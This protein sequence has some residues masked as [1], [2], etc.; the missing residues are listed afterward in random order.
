MKNPFVEEAYTKA[1]EVLRECE[2]DLGLKA[3]ALDEGY[4]QVWGR[5]SMISSLGILLTDDHTLQEASRKSLETLRA[6][7]TE[8]GLIPNNV[9]V[10]VKEA[11]YHAYMDGNFWYVIAVHAFFKKTNDQDFLKEYY[12]SVKKTLT[13]L[14]YQD[15][16]KSGLLSSQEATDWQDQFSVRG[17]IL[18][19]N[20]LYYQALRKGAELATIMGEKEN[21]R[22]YQ[23]R[24]EKV[25]RAINYLFWVRDTHKDMLP[26][27]ENGEKEFKNSSAIEF[28]KLL[29]AENSLY[30][31]RRPY[32]LAFRS[33]HQ[34]GEWF[35]TL[36]NMLAILFEVADSKKA[37]MILD[38]AAQAGIAMPYPAKAIDPPIFPGDTEWREYFKKANLNLPYQYHNGG[39]WPFVGGFY[40]AALVKA[41]RQEEAEKQLESLAKVNHLGKRYEW[42]F[43][44]WF[45]G[46]HGTPMG[47]EKQAWSAAMYVFAYHCVKSGKVL[48]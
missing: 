28:E 43:N 15:V 6:F 14:L 38:F 21:A 36:G 12:P 47:K 31:V 48:V 33:F 29:I 7:Q 34:H 5:D 37:Q 16:D 18:Y 44:E 4:H 25:K 30:L 45:H 10:H 11:D 22:E 32:F 19:D 17:K 27:V 2:S 3:S 20:V 42:E 40:V 26:L 39:I 41:G 1:L 9:D 23:E 46:M 8:L 35:D 24:A 13:W